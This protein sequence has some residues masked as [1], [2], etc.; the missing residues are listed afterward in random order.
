MSKY[1]DSKIEKLLNFFSE[2]HDDIPLQIH[3]GNVV[4]IEKRS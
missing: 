2:Q 4:C 1:V 3:Y